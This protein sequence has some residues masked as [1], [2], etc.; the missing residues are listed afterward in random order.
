MRGSRGP[1]LKT[2]P[3][4]ASAYPTG[5]DSERPYASEEQ[6]SPG[7]M[8]RQPNA[9]A[10]PKATLAAVRLCGQAV[11]ATNSSKNALCDLGCGAETFIAAGGGETDHH[12][13]LFLRFLAK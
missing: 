10:S 8:Q 1:G 2:P 9:T 13:E 4:E 3:P 5:S 11:L 12:L 6:R 7:G